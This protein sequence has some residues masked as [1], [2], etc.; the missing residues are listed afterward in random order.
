M[1]DYNEAKFGVI[2]YGSNEIEIV[3]TIDDFKEEHP[4]RSEIKKYHFYFKNIDDLFT[5]L[6]T[7][8]RLFK[9]LKEKFAKE[10]F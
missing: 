6:K 4:M 5:L 2:Y 7:D 3:E 8:K 9:E 1:V 10:E